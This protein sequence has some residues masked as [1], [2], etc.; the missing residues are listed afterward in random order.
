[1]DMNK[2]KQFAFEVLG[3]FMPERAY[4]IQEMSRGRVAIVVI[5][6]GLVEAPA[7]IVREDWNNAKAGTEFESVALYM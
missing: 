1:M 2:L 7:E 6:G 5:Y 4:T 3:D